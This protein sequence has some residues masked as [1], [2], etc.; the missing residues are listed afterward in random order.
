MRQHKGQVAWFQIKRE[1]KWVWAHEMWQARVE[2]FDGQ[3]HFGGTTNIVSCS[4]N[5][6][7]KEKTPLTSFLI[8]TL[9]SN[10]GKL[11][12]LR[13]TKEKGWYPNF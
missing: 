6:K 7:G 10:S 12:T 13:R 1:K 9:E 8:N 4:L 3:E 11:P 2:M 5:D